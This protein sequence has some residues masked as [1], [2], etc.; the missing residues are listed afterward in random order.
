M[1]PEFSTPV[2]A[3]SAESAQNRMQRATGR[4]ACAT[5]DAC[6]PAFWLLAPDYQLLPY[7]L[8]VPKTPLPIDAHL[9]E[10]HAALEQHRAV[11]VVAAPGA[12]K[13][14]RVPPHLA[15]HGKTIVLQPRRIAAR[16]L[17]RRIAYEQGW[18]AGNEVGWQMRNDRSFTPSTRLLVAT[19]GILTARMQSDPLLSEFSTI[20]LDEFHERSV[21]TDL[22]LA[23]AKQAWLARLDL[24][25]VVMSA[26]LDPA[27]VSAYLNDAP[28]LSIEGRLFPLEIEYRPDVS[29]STSI[30]ESVL[31][32]R[33]D[34]LVFL[35][36]ASEIELVR[37]EL[38]TLRGVRIF[39]LHGSLSGELQ[40][41]ALNPSNEQKVILSTNIAETSLTVEGITVVI[42]SGIQKTARYDDERGV[43]T[44]A[45]ERISRA[46]ADQRAGRAGRVR[47][48][49]V[50]RCWDRREILHE[51]QQPEIFRVDLAGTVLQILAWGAH[52]STFDWYEQ[53]EQSRIDAALHLLERI[54]AYAD[55]KITALGLRIVAIPLHPRLGAMLL[56]SQGDR[57]ISAACA[58]LSEGRRIDRRMGG[59]VSSSSDLLEV[60]D[61]L[62]SAADSTRVLESQLRKLVQDSAPAAAQSEAAF[63]KA[64]FSGYADRVGQRREKNS[65]RFLMSNGSGARLARESG[66]VNAEFIV[67][68]EMTSARSGDPIIRLASAVER[69][70]LSPTRKEITVT[71]N[72]DGRAAATERAWYDQILL[73]EQK[74]DVDRDSA[75][76][77]LI[78][79]TATLLREKNAAT[80]RRAEIAGVE[81]DV[82]ALV[83]EHYAHSDDAPKALDQLLTW[84]SAREIEKHAPELLPLPSGRTTRLDYRADGSI[85]ASVKLQELF[86]LGDTPRLGPRRLPV[87]FEMLSPAGRP[88]QTTSDLRSF[89]NNTYSEVRRELRAR[90]PKHPWPED[91]WTAQPTHKTIRKTK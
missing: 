7:Y 32:D 58:M 76:P 84:Q 8:P 10:I 52:P 87:T 35:P 56:A 60:G 11:I 88:M 69:S 51:R 3:A 36:G 46:S 20:I 73:W 14:T 75:R 78:E 24:R 1:W 83:N 2:R 91:P 5:Q 42:D 21:H 9:H 33:G 18:T 12:G 28:I 79:R 43:D 82:D 48:G 86:G 57:R 23:L 37:A 15:M 64:V 25:I 89:W 74:A 62:S 4:I 77:L 61:Q 66:V 27:P 72:P 40:D 13:T 16:A 81:I 19:E 55:A 41:A 80:L 85:V 50:I 59:S 65:D 53:P 38:G 45:P 26:T 39:S 17:A 63:L 29:V 71:I 54:G 67:A 34:H 70:W 49:K 44:L 47:S 90:Y 30:R 22:A 6:S 31:R 68:V